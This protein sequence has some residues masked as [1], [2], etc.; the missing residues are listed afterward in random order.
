MNRWH[1]YVQQREKTKTRL[2]HDLRLSIFRN[3]T[4]KVISFALRKI[5]S[6]W[7]RLTTQSI[8]IEQCTNSFITTI[9]LSCAYRIQHRIYDLTNERVV[10]LKASTKREI[11]RD[12]SRSISNIR[13]WDSQILLYDSRDQLVFARDRLE[14]TRIKILMLEINEIN[15]VFSELW[16]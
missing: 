2:S 4:R 11:S 14:I 16:N 12:S 3:L 8:I 7:K 1:N 9:R 10:L 15:E 6:Q 13:V 5:Y